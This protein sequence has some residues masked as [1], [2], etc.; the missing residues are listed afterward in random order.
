MVNG[1]QPAQEKPKF[2]FF[3]P[4][5]WPEFIINWF[6]RLPGIERFRFGRKRV[7]ERMHLIQYELNERWLA[8]NDRMFRD[9]IETIETFWDKQGILLGAG[10]NSLLDNQDGIVPL[11]NKLGAYSDR[12]R[13]GK[14]LLWFK[15]GT[16]YTEE[17]IKYQIPG[18][19]LW[20]RY[21]WDEIKTRKMMSDPRKP[22]EIMELTRLRLFGGVVFHEGKRELREEI[23]CFG[24]ERGTQIANAMLEFS[25]NMERRQLQRVGVPAYARSPIPDVAEGLKRLLEGIGRIETETYE[26]LHG[27]EGDMGRMEQLWKELV[28]KQ[29]PEAKKIT[30]RFPHTYRII[31]RYHIEHIKEKVRMTENGVVREH[32]NERDVEMYFEP[33][34][35]YEEEKTELQKELRNINTQMEGELK[36]TEIRI[37]KLEKS[38]RKIFK[39][40]KKD[41][42]SILGNIQSPDE[43]EKIIDFLNEKDKDLEV[44]LK[45]N[46]EQVTHNLE[47]IIT[48]PNK[49]SEE[50]LELIQ[51]FLLS[52]LTAI[53]E[54]ILIVYN[55]KSS[56]INY[57]LKEIGSITNIGEIKEKLTHNPTDNFYKRDEEL[58]YGL[59]EYG[60]PLEIDVDGSRTGEVG[61]VLI[62]FWWSEIAQNNWHLETIAL[63]RGGAEVLKRNL[64]IDVEY[65]EVEKEEVIAG[66]KEKKKELKV[67]RFIGTPKRTI[68]YIKDNRFYGY[69]DLLDAGTMIFA[70]WDAVRD[71]S[72][73]GRFHPYSKSVADYVIEGMG[74]FDEALGAPYPKSWVTISRPKGSYFTRRGVIP[75]GS[76]GIDY[77]INNKKIQIEAE[78]K[79]FENVPTEEKAVKQDFMMRLTKT[80]TGPLPD[81]IIETPYGYFYKGKRVPTKY[82]P[83]FDR[84]A[85]KLDYIHW[86]RMYY[87]EW[88]GGINRWSENPFPHI[89][90]RGIALYIAFLAAT[91]VYKYEDAEASL[92][93]HKFDYGVRGMGEYGL[94]N[95]LS[96]RG[97]LQEN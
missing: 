67:K 82:N 64:G 33:K 54:S 46:Y 20:T 88:A 91:D 63:K 13:I 24:L 71:D 85:E 74:G 68:R 83:A 39:D 31:K 86:G 23:Y 17:K 69:V 30:I 94:V 89:S 14:E 81:Y 53:R 51:T 22:W 32:L 72:R 29:T 49:S 47:D 36:I 41:L 65:E 37:S 25:Q 97:I 12:E 90:T 96:G 84:R 19:E 80:P 92:E 35:I 34:D 5:E 60:Y 15:D 3:R 59:D 57:R 18:R 55:A 56:R 42:I 75:L 9:V 87:W 6:K 95:P 44:L 8:L 45:E 10:K 7:G 2:A 11:Y 27:F 48:E 28:L 77:E 79:L 21:G 78:P 43:I 73:D 4:S 38:I 58:E 26:M 40:G 76:T 70:Y 61:T 50:I 16:G 66:I 62:D 52:F 93:G 1:Q